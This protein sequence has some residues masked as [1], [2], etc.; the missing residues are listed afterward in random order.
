VIR[1]TDTRPRP[2]TFAHCSQVEVGDLALVLRNPLG[3]RSGVTEGIGRVIGTPTLAAPDPQMGA[4]EAP[5]IGFAIDGNN[6][7]RSRGLSPAR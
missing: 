6:V 1:I 7:R 3:L 5:G 4:G 2:A